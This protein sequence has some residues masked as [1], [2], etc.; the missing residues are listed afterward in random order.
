MRA[1]DLFFLDYS[2]IIIISATEMPAPTFKRFAYRKNGWFKRKQEI[3][4]QYI[5]ELTKNGE[6]IKRII[7]IYDLGTKALE[8]YLMRLTVREEEIQT[9]DAKLISDIIAN[10]DRIKRLE[11][12]RPTEIVERYD[13]LDIKDLRA[14]A[15][16]V[17]IE[18][19]RDDGIVN[20]LEGADE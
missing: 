17:L 3:Q 16:E 8:K 10:I 5:K 11:E 18:L 1:R 7:R 14:K 2:P 20:Y 6:S 12:G 15:R 4:E 13:T 19:Q 9:K